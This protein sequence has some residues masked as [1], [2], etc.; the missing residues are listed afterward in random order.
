LGKLVSAVRWRW[1][2]LIFDVR[3]LIE[4]IVNFPFEKRRGGVPKI[5]LKTHSINGQSPN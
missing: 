1:G 3:N 5:P 2:S 4:F